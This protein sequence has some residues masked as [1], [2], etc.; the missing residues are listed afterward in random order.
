MR[1]ITFSFFFF[2]CIY[3]SG[4][5]AQCSSNISTIKV[6]QE[7]FSTGSTVDVIPNGLKLDNNG[8]LCTDFASMIDGP[9]MFGPN[10][11]IT[12]GNNASAKRQAMVFYHVSA[13]RAW[14]SNNLPSSLISSLDG[15]LEFKVEDVGKALFMVDKPMNATIDYRKR[16][17]NDPGGDTYQAFA[18]D[19][20]AIASG[21]FQAA[22]INAL[23][24][25][26]ETPE[27][28]LPQDEG[29]LFGI[30]D[31][32][33][34]RYMSS[35][36]YN[37]GTQMYVHAGVGSDDW[38]TLNI[39]YA[40]IDYEY[41]DNKFVNNKT[42]QEQSE[43]L[44]AT[45]NHLTNI[46]DYDILGNQTNLGNTKVDA[47]VVN[48]MV[49][50]NNSTVTSGQSDAAKILYDQAV[51][52]GLDE[53]DLCRIL[54]LFTYVYGTAFFTSDTYVPSADQGDIFIKD[55]AADNGVGASEGIV[56][57]SPSLWNR[58]AK[59]FQSVHLAPTPV[60]TTNENVTNY[61]HVKLSGNF[62][63]LASVA[64]AAALKMQVHFSINGTAWW[65]T[66]WTNDN[67]VNYPKGDLIG[68]L[69][70]ET[71][72]WTDDYGNVTMIDE[73]HLK[74]TASGL[75]N[76]EPF[77]TIALP[78]RVA[79]FRSWS[80]L[81]FSKKATLGFHAI[82]LSESFDPMS[83]SDL[84]WNVETNTKNK[85][86]AALKNTIIIP[87]GYGGIQLPQVPKSYNPFV[88]PHDPDPDPITPDPDYTIGLDP[89]TH[90]PNPEENDD[91][92]YE[93]LP[94]A[95]NDYFDYGQVIF[96][97]DDDLFAAW[98]AGGGRGTGFIIN[99]DNEIEVTGR[100]FVLQ[101]LPFP[102]RDLENII[103]FN[104]VSNTLPGRT[105]FDIVQSRTNGEEIGR[106][107]VEIREAL[108]GNRSQK[109]NNIES[110]SIS[111][112]PNPINGVL[113]YVENLNSEGTYTIY[114][115]DGKTHTQARY[116]KDQQSLNLTGLNKGVYFIRFAKENGE[117]ETK[118][119]IK[120]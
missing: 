82:M 116:S 65:P 6:Y 14:A 100:D 55:N 12:Q 79:P 97:M 40:A 17:M 49:N 45:L 11:D 15:N 44:S 57:N 94:D 37:T 30:S 83:L 31:Y 117:V 76:G 113:L 9:K 71:A 78:Y 118:K 48:A 109:E 29:V 4:I 13:A 10:I 46:L 25:S 95:Y 19:A 28:Q 86:N 8:H 3:S 119:L 80:P 52:N 84:G 39:D 60:Y 43:L 51:V 26:V 89:S 68:V 38:S 62:C 67:V 111:I 73:S 98:Q 23:S 99:S 56:H 106:V 77:I 5:N 53:F 75:L 102:D 90:D 22:H 41:G 58:H 120:M 93:P 85:N 81:K 42:S 63:D 34:Y 114:G 115:I 96:A 70:F 87:R 72:E 92:D 110:L 91:P 24:S 36:G 88:V 21:Y 16:D 74:V 66:K 35:K 27:G 1:L 47:M 7:S 61:I 18:E 104:F 50:L 2:C 32:L 54:N 101:G 20:F 107:H 112:Y 105:G 108:S 59:D 103:G 64:K 69:D 33:A